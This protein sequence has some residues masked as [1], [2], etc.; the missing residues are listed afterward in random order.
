MRAFEIR[1]ASLDAFAPQPCGWHMGTVHA[2]LAYL[3]GAFVIG[4]YE[5]AD[6]DQR[7]LKKVWQVFD[8]F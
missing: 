6:G 2:N 8:L 7:E 4:S 1:N 5:H 3:E